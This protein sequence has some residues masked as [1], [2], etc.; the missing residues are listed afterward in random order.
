MAAFL[1]LPLILRA[2]IFGFQLG[3]LFILVGADDRHRGGFDKLA[4]ARKS[5][6]IFVGTEDIA[7]EIERLVGVLVG[8]IFQ[9]RTVADDGCNFVVDERVCCFRHVIESNGRDGT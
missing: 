5:K 7:D 2:K 8:V 3:N 4:M 9:H 6:A 1:H